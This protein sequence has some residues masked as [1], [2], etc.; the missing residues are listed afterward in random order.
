[1]PGQPTPVPLLLLRIE[2]S[3]LQNGA[4]LLGGGG[5]QEDSVE[6]G[7]GAR[8]CPERRDGYF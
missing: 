6:G 3:G 2:P 8:R 5:G 7:R 4:A 1:M